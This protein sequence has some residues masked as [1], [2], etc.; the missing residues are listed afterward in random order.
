MN[1]RC[2]SP[3]DLTCRRFL[4][5]SVTGALAVAATTLLLLNL[6]SCAG[7]TRLITRAGLDP[8]SLEERISDRFSRVHC[9]HLPTPLE[10]MRVLSRELN[11]PT[12]FI[13]RD[14][15][16]GLAFGGNKARKLEFIIADAI[17]KNADVIITWAGIQSNWCRQTAA[18][19]RMYGIQPILVL[20]KR[21]TS[22][23][24]Y[25]GNL[26]LDLILGADVRIL[27]PDDDR[28]Q[29]VE[30]I[31]EEEKAKGHNPY[32]VP[33]GGS[34]VGG[35]MTEP[36][37]AIGYVQ[38]FVEIFN[39]AQEKR[40]IIDHV[41][42]ATGSGGTQ[43]GLVVGAKALGADVKIIGISVSGAE[44]SIQRNVAGIANM[45]ADA[46]GLDMTFSPE[47]IIVIDDYVG[48]GYGVLNEEIAATISLLAR[49]EGIL[50]DPVYTGKA[51]SGL[52]D[53][54]RT[55]YFNKDDHVVF[56]HTGGTPALFAY[57]EKLLD[58]IKYN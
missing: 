55:N 32:V 53:L 31:T 6:P 30:Q 46:L 23:V 26:L 43:A 39:D 49:K 51:M 15:Q 17:D 58:F 50:L 22:S 54:V 5:R 16:T 27:E 33:V 14:D 40:I 44:A 34:S 10:E 24:A 7:P 37:G 38:A 19:A 28:V 42:V 3:E 13:K 4:H 35:S 11:G 25:D 52:I 47:E 29:I 20:S 2:H 8:A 36:L 41:V 21:D 45:T 48:E 57:K 12:L 56:I 18:A 9:A 1:S